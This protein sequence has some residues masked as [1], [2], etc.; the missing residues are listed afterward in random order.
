MKSSL[1]RAIISL[2]AGILLVKYRVDMVKWLTISIGAMFFISGVISVVYYFVA[3]KKSQKL[4]SEQKSNDPEVAPVL[5]NKPTLPIVGLG[6]AILGIILALMPTTFVTY[7][8]Y[9]FAAIIILGAVGEYV[10]LLTNNS[11]VRDFEKETKIVAEVSFGF[12][13]WIMPTLLLL[14]GII[15]ILY[16][17]GIASAPFL[18]MGIALIVYGVSVLINAVKFLSAR[19]KISKKRKAILIIKEEEPVIVED[20][21]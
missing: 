11:V 17:Q 14:F 15:A 6:C 8:V 2:I 18:F 13:Y 9:V 10:A 21:Q 1:I 7:I 5:V 3:N 16:P 4:P 20:V 19:K 12:K